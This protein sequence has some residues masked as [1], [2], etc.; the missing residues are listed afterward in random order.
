MCIC[1]QRRKEEAAGGSN[2]QLS[3][4]FP[5]PIPF[6]YLSKHQRPDFN[7]LP[8]FPPFSLRIHKRR[9]RHPLP[10][11]LTI[12]AQ[13]QYPLLLCHATPI[14]PLLRL[15]MSDSC[16]LACSIGIAMLDWHDVL[17]LQGICF[18]ECERR[19]FNGAVNGAPHI[20]DAIAAC[21][22]CS[23]FFLAG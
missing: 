2:V 15:A 9:M 18:C 1:I 11:P 7:T 12:K 10:L 19:G 6:K 3:Q 16:S 23:R 14:P 13:Q 22:P 8:R 4:P 17:H 20:D 21:E 5:R